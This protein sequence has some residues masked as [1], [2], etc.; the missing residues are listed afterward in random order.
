MNL[1]LTNFMTWCCIKY[2]LPELTMLVVIGTDCIGGYKSNYHT[3]K[4]SPGPWYKISRFV[5]LLL[6]NMTRCSPSLNNSVIFNWKISSEHHGGIYILLLFF[7]RFLIN[8][9]IIIRWHLPVFLP[10]ISSGILT[11]SFSL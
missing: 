5:S 2:T 7:F 3:T 9:N 11:L 1:S 10:V 8:I 6:L 4:T